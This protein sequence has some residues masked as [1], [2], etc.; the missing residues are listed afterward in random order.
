MP[1]LWHKRIMLGAAAN[2]IFC[3]L[4][5]DHMLNGKLRP[6]SRR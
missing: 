5:A 1:Y 3:V 4:A 2:Y 6:L